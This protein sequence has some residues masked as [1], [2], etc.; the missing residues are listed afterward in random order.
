[1]PAPFPHNQL[2]GLLAILQGD[3]KIA[4]YGL[5]NVRDERLGRMF[6]TPGCIEW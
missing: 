3:T 2:R 6:L 5:G 4:L 1:M